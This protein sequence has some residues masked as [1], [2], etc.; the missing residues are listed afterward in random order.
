MKTECAFFLA[1]D[2]AMHAALRSAAS[3]KTASIEYPT[4]SLADYESKD[5]HRP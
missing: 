5:T 2:A 4:N 1:Q 3:L